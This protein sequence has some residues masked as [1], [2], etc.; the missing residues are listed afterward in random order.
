M[1]EQNIED[2]SS[3]MCRQLVENL[4]RKNEALR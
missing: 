4:R 2:I 3:K 1:G